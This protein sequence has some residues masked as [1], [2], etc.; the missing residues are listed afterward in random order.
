VPGFEPPP[1][2][3]AEHDH[4]APG[5]VRHGLVL[6]GVY[7]AVYAGFVVLN[8]FLPQVM[9]SRVIGISLAVVYGLALIIAAFVLAVVYAWLCRS[10][11]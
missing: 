2:T 3:T 4:E 10:R 8:A 1:P 9:E 11:P 7:L 5:K 6:V